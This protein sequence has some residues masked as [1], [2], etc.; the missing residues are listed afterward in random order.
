MY[1]NLSLLFVYF[2]LYAI[3]GWMCEVVYCSIPE[4]KFINRGFLNGPY[5][6][7]YGVGALIIIM[8]LMPYVSD[9]ILVFFI[10]IILT[11][12]LEYVTSWGMEKLFHAK[13]WDYS[14]H[15][16]NINGRVCLLNSFLFGLLCVILMYVVHPIVNDLVNS[17]SAFWIQV[18]A[19]IAAVFF[20]SD[21]VES[22]RETVSFNKKLGSVYE[23]TTELKDH[24][25]EKGIT[26][27]HEVTAKVRDL[28]DGTLTEAKDSAHHLIVSL[29]NR[30][31]ENKVIN[32]YSHRRIMNAFPKMSHL[33]HQ[34][35]L[36]IYKAFMEK[37]KAKH[38]KI[39]AN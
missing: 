3:I 15:K 8:F 9:P 7:I 18:I 4:K 17:F 5:C 39:D 30:I 29:T 36:E 2:F 28:K 6:P 19:T 32:R 10:G 26:T 35:S 12:T 1:Y 16:F 34:T 14:D 37:N 31:S 24:L 25:K 38:T 22:T 20:V 13:W 11:S 33:N 23:A 27:A 21:L